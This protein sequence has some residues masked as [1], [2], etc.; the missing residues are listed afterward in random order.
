MGS[1]TDHIDKWERMLSAI[2]E[3]ESFG[4]ILEA[5]EGYQDLVNLIKNTMQDK[6]SKRPIDISADEKM[7]LTKL[8]KCLLARKQVLVNQNVGFDISIADI[9]AIQKSFKKIFQGSPF[10][11]DTMPFA[12]IKL[13]TAEPEPD[14]PFLDE[15]R[16]T[17]LPCPTKLRPGEEIIKLFIS[18][19]G[20]K[21]AATYLDPFFNISIRDAE[22]NE[23]EQE[24][25][26]PHPVGPR[27]DKSVQF[28]CTVF[29]QTPM[30]RLPDDAA[31]FFE[32]R[33]YKPKQTKISTRCW[34]LLTLEEIRKHKDTS[35]TLEIYAKPADYKRKKFARH[36]VKDL[37][38]HVTLG[39]VKG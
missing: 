35:L 19:I 13:A 28:D 32:F 5:T 18:N 6:D 36:S 21:D 31:I 10:P 24:Q 30:S 22:G 16:G 33:H 4:Q 11:V 38:L 9:R 2:L 27:K 14:A 39:F 29:V 3:E 15:N 25:D 23:L 20:L 7:V 1:I 37:W 17:L 26:T 34:A 8:Q 12:S